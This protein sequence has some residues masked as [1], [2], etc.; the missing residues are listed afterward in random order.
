MYSAVGGT[1]GVGSRTL[2]ICHA[3]VCSAIVSLFGQAFGC[4]GSEL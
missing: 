4:F 1:G 2:S 3:A